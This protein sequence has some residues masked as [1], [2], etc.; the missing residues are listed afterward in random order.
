MSCALFAR[1]DPQPWWEV[2]IG[3]GKPSNVTTVGTIRLWNRVPET[4]V[5][6]VDVIFASCPPVSV[7]VI[8]HLS[9]R[10][11]SLKCGHPT[12]FLQHS[13]STCRLLI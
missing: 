8:S 1:F 4:N 10:F 6:E 11:K 7:V 12:P 2:E 13:R 5:P 9:R 3:Y